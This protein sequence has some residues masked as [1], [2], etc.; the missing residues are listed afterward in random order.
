MTDSSDLHAKILVQCHESAA[1]RA[2]AD[3]W[4][5]EK[6]EKEVRRW[7][8][9]QLIDYKDAMRLAQTY[10][11][12]LSLEILKGC[13]AATETTYLPSHD[14]TLSPRHA[15][16]PDPFLT[17][18]GAHAIGV[19]APPSPSPSNATSVSRM[20]LA[21]ETITVLVGRE[22][23]QLT[24]ERINRD[25]SFISTDVVTRLY[26]NVQLQN[27]T[28]I[29]LTGVSQTRGPLYSCSGVVLTF[30]CSPERT[31]TRQVFFYLVGTM[32]VDVLLGHCDYCN[33]YSDARISNG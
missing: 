22:Q 12:K 16:N 23:L 4:P 30:F 10:K 3:T 28:P 17:R 9:D 20:A 7:C 1:R 26:P 5:A 15:Q 33:C 32:D 2:I 31:R 24:M 19:R 8:D 29:H 18:S 6:V 25:C 21:P 11:G 14:P 13:V 27:T